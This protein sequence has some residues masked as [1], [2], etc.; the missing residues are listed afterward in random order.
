MQQ[1]R[2]YLGSQGYNTMRTQQKGKKK[3]KKR[4]DRDF[5]GEPFLRSSS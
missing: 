2:K 1:G 5:V 4:D 3:K